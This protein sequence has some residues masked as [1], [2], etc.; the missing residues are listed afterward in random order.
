VRKL[1]ILLAALA[2]GSVQAADVKVIAES[3]GALVG[4]VGG[5]LKEPVGI[6]QWLPGYGFHIAARPLLG[7]SAGLEDAITA[8]KQL[9]PALVGTVKGLASSGDWVSVG[10]KTSAYQLIV[11]VRPYD[12][13]VIEVWVDGVQR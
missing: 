7:E 4:A 6:A 10:Y 3:S 11:R 5:A 1:V 8:L 13:T 2:F 9:L 12:L